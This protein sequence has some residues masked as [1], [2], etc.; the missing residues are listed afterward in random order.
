MEPLISSCTINSI[1]DLASLFP[2]GNLPTA[3]D[4]CDGNVP[5][6]L[7][8]SSI[9][10]IESNTEVE[11]AFTDTSGNTSSSNLNQSIVIR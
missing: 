10:P 2:S 8:D 11:W 4:N 1:T 3:T 6:V 7:A 5:G 9:F